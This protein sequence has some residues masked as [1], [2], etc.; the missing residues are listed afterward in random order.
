M[1]TPSYVWQEYA[2]APTSHALV[3][4]NITGGYLSPNSPRSVSS[5]SVSSPRHAQNRSPRDS[6]SKDHNIY[7]SQGASTI[8]GPEHTSPRHGH[9]HIR[10]HD[11]NSCGQN[12]EATHG[13]GICAGIHPDVLAHDRVTVYGQSASKAPKVEPQT[14][15]V[16]V[17]SPALSGH[18]QARM[19]EEALYSPLPPNSAPHRPISREKTSNASRR[20]KF[21]REALGDAA[22]LAPTSP[23]RLV[24]RAG[25]HNSHKDLSPGGSIS[26]LTVP[27]SLN[28]DRL[29]HVGTRMHACDGDG[30]EFG[31]KILPGDDDDGGKDDFEDEDAVKIAVQ[32][33]GIVCVAKLVRCA[34]FSCTILCRF[35]VAVFV[36][37]S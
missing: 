3:T 6:Q 29:S 12:K 37:E 19:L 27:V 10:N 24:K 9:A 35:C 18:A 33:R 36:A 7:A 5:R 34:H 26:G 15:P 22:K 25:F 8:Y 4:E 31:A 11:S 32:V 28:R 14:Q 16:T 1:W 13:S 17:N 30:A 21:R 20:D 2:S 23:Q